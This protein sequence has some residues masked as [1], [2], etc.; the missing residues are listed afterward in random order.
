MLY[1]FEGASPELPASGSAYVAPG[2]HVIGR[3][4]L[5]EQ[6]SVWFGAVLRGDN[7]WISIGDRSNVQDNCVFHTDP[8]RPL[9][10][11][12]DC[13]IGHAAILHGCIVEDQTL[14]GMGATILNRAKI[15]RCSIVG[16]GALI[17]ENKEFPP[18]SLIVGAPAKAV[19]T[20]EGEAVAAILRS[21][22]SYAARAGRYRQ[23]LTPLGPAVVTE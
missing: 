15:G 12:A 14:I 21:A 3:V 7:E 5:G 6:A 16:A 4:R 2:A 19:R 13:T 9:V 20:L 23:G 18:F 17:T 22:A 8:G 1:A 10:I 11:G